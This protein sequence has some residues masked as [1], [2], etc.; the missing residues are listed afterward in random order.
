MFLSK[1]FFHLIEI[2]ELIFIF[3]SKLCT[4]DNSFSRERKNVV[5]IVKVK[6]FVVQFLK[7]LFQFHYEFLKLTSPL[8]HAVFL[9]LNNILQLQIVSFRL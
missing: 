9:C 4:Y 8:G 2:R 1:F 3:L 6:L 5:L 7:S